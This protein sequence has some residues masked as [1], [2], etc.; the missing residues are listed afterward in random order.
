[1]NAAELILVVLGATLL[2]ATIFEL[3]FRPRPPRDPNAD[4]YYDRHEGGG[5]W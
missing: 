2:V 5:K 1:M 3:R 4:D